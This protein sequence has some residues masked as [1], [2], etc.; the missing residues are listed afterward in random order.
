MKKARAFIVHRFEF[1]V[2][3]SA[4]RSRFG[5][6]VAQCLESALLGNAVSFQ[7]AFPKPC[8]KKA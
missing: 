2:D 6:A 7:P 5:F 8:A 4:R 3:G 1:I